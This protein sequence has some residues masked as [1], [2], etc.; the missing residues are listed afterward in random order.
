MHSGASK[1]APIPTYVIMCALKEIRTHTCIRYYLLHT[2]QF[3]TVTDRSE[4]F[5]LL[6]IHQ[7]LAISL[8]NATMR[9]VAVM[10]G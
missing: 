8:R 9:W 6:R 7:L 3:T 10:R 5:P 4:G 1:H 2:P